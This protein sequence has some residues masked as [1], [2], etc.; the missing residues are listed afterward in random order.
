MSVVSDAFHAVLLVVAA[1]VEAVFD[2]FVQNVFAVGAVVS[3]APVVWWH[4]SAFAVVAEVADLI[5][6]FNHVVRLGLVVDVGSH[7]SYY[8][9]ACWPG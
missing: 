6:P 5:R 4:V 9:A 2:V 8:I 1:A 3:G 7:T